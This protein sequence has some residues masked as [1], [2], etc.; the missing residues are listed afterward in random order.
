M[1]LRNLF[2]STLI[3]G[4]IFC[5]DCRAGLEGFTSANPY[6]QA[7]L[8]AQKSGFPRKILNYRDAMRQNV[9]MLNRYAKSKNPNFITL[10]HEGEDLLSDS[11]WE[12]H[13]EDYNNSRAL[14]YAAENDTLL[15]TEEETRKKKLNNLSKEYNQNIDALVLN[16]LFCQYHKKVS[17]G[18]IPLISIDQCSAQ[19]LDSAIEESVR[20]RSLI[21]I[22]SNPQYAFKDAKDQLLINENAKNIEKLSEARN[23]LFLLDTSKYKDKEAYLSDIR[24]SNFD[25]VVISPF[26]QGKPLDKEDINE[27]KYKKNGALR[28]VVAEFNISEADPNKYY[29][30]PEWKIGSPSWLKRLSFVDKES[31]IVEYWSE[32]WQNIISKY[33]KGIM[34]L[35]FDGVFLTGL[36]NHKYFEDLTPL[37]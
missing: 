12:Y 10:V 37:E 5:T 2:L 1:L 18:K 15:S 16:N 23:I 33:F 13:L 29:W 30:Q 17:A 24:N 34:A 21:Y 4:L 27:L 22:F 11:L 6:T 35:D 26:F 28:K 8:D 19:D 25:I 31:V 9:I 36:N 14:G 3:L 20:Q 7:E 32:E